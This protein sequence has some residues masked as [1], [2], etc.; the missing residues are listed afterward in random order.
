MVYCAWWM[1]LT[2][3]TLI[4]ALSFLEP[5][6]RPL[7]MEEKR[8]DAGILSPPS[9]AVGAES[10]ASEPA[11]TRR[12]AGGQKRKSN[13]L[14]ASNSSSASSKRIT[15]EKSM[16]IS[17]PPIHN[18]PL[19]RARQAPNNLASG[20]ALVSGSANSVLG[21]KLEEDKAAAAYK[22]EEEAMNRRSEEWMALEAKIESEF[23]AIRSRDSSAHA[24]PNHCGWFSW[25]KIHPLEERSL[26]SFF[27]GKSQARTPDI[28][29]QIR[30]WIMKRFHANPNTQIELK[31]LS[32]LEV[33]DLDA[34]QEVMEFLDYWGLINF[35]PFLSAD[36]ASAG[37]ICDVLEKKDPLIDKLYHFEAIQYTPVIPK[38]HLTT[39][40]MPS[41]LFP[42]SAIAE[43]LVK[44]EGPAVEYHC[45]SCSADC[46]RKR[47]HCQKQADFDLCT[48]CFN[49]GKFGSN[50]SSSD[51]IL[52]EPAEAPGFSGGKWTDQET[53]LLLEALEL[54]N[55]NWNEIA[56]HVATKTKAQCILHF[57]Q[58]PIEDTFLDSA[59][60][61]DATSKE[62]ADLSATNNDNT[63]TSKNVPETTEG[64]TVANDGQSTCL[65]TLK[66]E[67]ASEMKVCK[68]TSKPVE[69]I[70]VKVVEET[71]RSKDTNEVKDGCQTSDDLALMALK[72]AFEAVGYPL[73]ADRPHSFADVGNPVMTLAAFLAKLVGCDVAAVSARASLKSISG[74]SPGLQLAARHSF[75]LEDPPNDIKEPSGSESAIAEMCSEN[76]NKYEKPED[77]NNKEDISASVLDDKDSANNHG[78]KKDEDS[79]TE[80]NEASVSTIDESTVMVNASKE[81]RK[82]THEEDSHGNLKESMNVK[83]PEDQQPSTVKEQNNLAT[84]VP[85]SSLQEPVSET[86]A[87]EL[88]QPVEPAKDVNVPSDCFPADKNEQYELHTSNSVG[89]ASQHA[90][91]GKDAVMA[92]SP[93][94]NEPQE[95][96]TTVG[97]ESCQQTEVAKDVE[98]VLSQ[99]PVS[100]NS[101]VENGAAAGEDQKWEMAK[102]DKDDG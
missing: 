9:S 58:M 31:D 18:G 23:E 46:S 69:T 80:G 29:M 22:R 30:N 65:E 67:N 8:R 24:V 28:Y 36:S 82:T 21:A 41:R 2:T 90:E 62:A 7:D 3:A 86:L 11:S 73:N 17:H 12:R 20:S 89:E 101:P 99:Q 15:R 16:L 75:L 27:N 77:K 93:E 52:M 57:V 25:T 55:E 26:P 76:A 66:P 43:E 50:M 33:G 85:E 102:K 44:Q 92:E 95:P 78:D 74:N 97:H 59:D 87:E 40:T 96:V 54:Y 45:N 39:P 4:T 47:Y 5:R 72:E 60:D 63:S 56:E 91:G 98:M 48:E 51:F 94:K 6:K 42:D 49:N 32:E 81:G 88:S 34:R 70:E 1:L 84:E 79:V 13:A 10:P 38:P 71:S 53:L 14:A 19:T 37:V 83:L 100:S 35:H 68:E 64:N 61:E